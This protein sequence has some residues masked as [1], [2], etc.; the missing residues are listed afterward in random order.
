MRKNIFILL[1][2]CMAIVPIDRLFGDEIQQIENSSGWKPLLISPTE[3]DAV[4]I[5]PSFRQLAYQNNQLGAMICFGLAT[6]ND[7]NWRSNPDPK[8]F[9]PS[10]LNAEQ[11][12][13]VAKSFGAKQIVLVAKHHCGFCLWPTKTTDYCVSSSPWKNGKGDVVREFADACRKHKIGMGLYLSPADLHFKCRSVGTLNN[14]GTP[15]YRKLEGD[16]DSYFLYYMAQ[17]KELLTNYGELTELWMDGYTDPFG[18]DVLDPKTGQPIGSAHGKA[19]FDLIR[20]FQP[21]AVIFNGTHNPDARWSGSEQGWAP[22]PLWNIVRKGQGLK[23]WLPADAQGWYCP[24]AC[25]H[26]R[27]TWFWKSDTDQTLRSVEYLLQ[28]YHNSIGR[29]ANLLVN[30]TPDNRGLIPDAEVK[31]M[32]QF[33]AE[34]KRRFNVPLART[35]SLKGWTQPGLLEIHLAKIQTVNHVILEEDIA[36]GQHIL[37]YAIDAFIDGKWKTLA[38]GKSVGRKRIEQFESVST[39]KIRLRINKADTIPAV[40]EMA[41]YNV[42][43]QSL[44]N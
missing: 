42:S 28:A 14:S 26:T 12:V 30:I 9:N 6:F 2:L 11:W 1:V 15:V 38:E 20:Q 44:T 19:L 27:D 16:R 25:I 13:N 40:K 35:N 23:N 34:L 21:N 10:N 4:K 18:P 37:A 17:L 41:V 22:Y 8:I 31:R 43:R 24:E 33:G 39:E 7:G 29:G 32:A 36:R 5:I 3:E